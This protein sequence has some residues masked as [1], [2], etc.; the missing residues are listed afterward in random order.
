ME[1]RRAFLSLALFVFGVAGVVAA[2]AIYRGPTATV[3]PPAPP[4]GRI[5][6][7]ASLA[8]AGALRLPPEKPCLAGP[9]DVAAEEGMEASA[10][11]DFD[12]VRQVMRG[13]V[14][15]T[16][17]CF[18]NAASTTVQLEITVACTGRVARVDVADDGG[19]SPDVVGCVK[20]V[21]RYAAFPA[22][23]L[24]DGDTFEYPLSYNAPG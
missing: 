4:K 2:T 21:M 20:D 15:Q 16:L 6:A 11:L 12:Q 8:P 7:T 18:G 22:H 13:F 3:V 5:A 14:P 17:K 9:S 10:G 19:A 24:P 1:A 23:A